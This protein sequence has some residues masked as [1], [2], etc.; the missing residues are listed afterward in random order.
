[1]PGLIFS[2]NHQPKS[3]FP[4]GKGALFFRS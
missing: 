1:M 4:P 3:P 2:S